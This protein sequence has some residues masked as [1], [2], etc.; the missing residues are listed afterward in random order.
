[1]G[2]RIEVAILSVAAGLILFWYAGENRAQP[3]LAIGPDAEV[4]EDGLH[5]MDPSIMGA[6]WVK[7]DLDLSRYDRIYFMPAVTQFREIVE[8]QY[9]ARTIRNATEFPV[10]ETEKIRLREL[11]GEVFYEIIEDVESYEL[12]DKLGREVLMVR[13]FLTDVISGV[14][15]DIPGSTVNIVRW[16]WEVNVVLELRD[17][18][19]D[20][21]LARTVERLRLDGPMDATEVWVL[22]PRAVR[23]WSS[24][25]ALRLDELSDLSTTGSRPL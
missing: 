13:G 15:P 24:L 23:S 21:V 9:S 10:R 1:M 25:L 3:I 18:M 17:S 8:R 5:R 7:P 20:E 12:T 19:S 14:P 6:A 16:A 22:T 4:T 11:F 2:H